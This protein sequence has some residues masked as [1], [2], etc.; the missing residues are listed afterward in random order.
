MNMGRRIFSDE[1]MSFRG[2]GEGRISGLTAYESCSRRS[3]RGVGEGGVSRRAFVKTAATLGLA[4][5]IA[6]TSGCAPKQNV[7]EGARTEEDPF[8]GAQEF[9]AACPPECQHHNLKALVKDGKVVKVE[10]GVNK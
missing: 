7:K 10:C 2:V 1:C 3:F 9:F 8:E 6:E 5:S 4:A